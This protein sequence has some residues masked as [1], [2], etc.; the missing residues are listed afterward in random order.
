MKQGDIL[1]EFESEKSAM[2]FEAPANGVLIRQR[3]TLSLSF[4]HR[5]ADGAT[6]AKFLQ[7]IK[8]L[9]ERPFA[10]LVGVS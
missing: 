1:F 9:V 4:D 2:E 5:L 10:L 3:M 7:R 6:A 8:H